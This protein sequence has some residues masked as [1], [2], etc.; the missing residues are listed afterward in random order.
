MN[1]VRRGF[2]PPLSSLIAF[3]CAARLG[4]I[5]RASDELHLT[6]SAVSRQILQLETTLGVEMFKRIRQR[7][8]LTEAG[9]AYANE[10]RGILASLSEAT[11]N[12]IASGGTTESLNLAV[13]PTFGTRWLVPRLPDFLETRPG[14]LVNLDTRVVPFD[15]AGQ[16]FDAAIHFGA[17]DWPG[18]VCQYLMSEDLVPVCHPDYRQRLGIA[19]L[20]DL[21]KGTLLQQTTRPFAWAEWL[22]K[23]GIGTATA[24]KGPRF[25]QFTMMA[26][27]AAVG[28]GIALVPKFLIEEELASGRLEILFDHGLRSSQAYYVVTPEAKMGAPL[29]EQFKEWLVAQARAADPAGQRSVV[30]PGLDPGVHVDGRVKPGHD[31]GG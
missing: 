12:V 25:E 2:L 7:I 29:V 10:V 19:R 20:D 8:V 23:V 28:M 26:Q 17:A 27:A 9:R 4:S 15:F 1:M 30:T 22:E 18:A 14:V 13:L 11:H 6:Q 21:T 16:P 24:L 3:E 5:S 31:E